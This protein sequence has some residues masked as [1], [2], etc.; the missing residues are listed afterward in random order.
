ML[1]NLTLNISIVSVLVMS[2]IHWVADFHMQT[3]DMATKKS[4]SNYW[5][6]MHVLV[7]TGVTVL[8]WHFTFMQPAIYT[9][10]EY[11]YFANFIFWT[12]WIT[13]YFTSRMTSKLYAQN[14]YHDFFVVIG[15]D[16]LLHTAELLAAYKLFVK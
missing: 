15:F 4:K 14:R 6:T 10:K 7:Y 1:D 5:L 3:E 2:F 12:H 9:L 11:F 8:F 16:Q 13:D